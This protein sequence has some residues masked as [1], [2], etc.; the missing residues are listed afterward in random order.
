MIFFGVYVFSYILLNCL[1]VKVFFFGRHIHIIDSQLSLPGAWKQNVAFRE[2]RAVFRNDQNWG[3]ISFVE[4][5][6]DCLAKF[7]NILNG[8]VRQENEAN[9]SCPCSESY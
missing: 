9:T 2:R 8:H 1:L 4:A 3:K 7:T 6:S 5:H